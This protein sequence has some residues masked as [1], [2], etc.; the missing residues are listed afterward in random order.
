M[1]RICVIVA[2]IFSFLFLNSMSLAD[3]APIVEEEPV[4]EMINMVD[5]YRENPEILK[6]KTQPITDAKWLATIVDAVAPNSDDNCKLAIME[7]I[8]NRTRASGFPNTIEGVCAEKNQWQGYTNDSTYT[9]ETYKLAKNFRNSIKEPRISPING[10]M[11]YMR[12]D[13]TGLYFRNSWDSNYEY[14]VPYF[15]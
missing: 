4:A 1:K 7:C 8:V 3:D 12:V 13:Y 9:D 6:E 11:V 5:V 10:D 15:S 2:V 14:F